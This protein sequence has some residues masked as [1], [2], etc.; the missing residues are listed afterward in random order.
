MSWITIVLIA[1]F[2][3]LGIGDSAPKGGWKQYLKD[4]DDKKQKEDDRDA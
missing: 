3:L 2:I 1:L 4:L